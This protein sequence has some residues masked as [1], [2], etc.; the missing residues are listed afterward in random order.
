VPL[1]AG[2]SEAARLAERLYAGLLEAGVDAVIDDRADHPG[3]KLTDVE[4]VGI[5]Y[6][7]VVGP[8]G[9]ADGVVEL[10]S[11]RSGDTA[12]IPLDEAVA[13]VGAELARAAAAAEVQDLR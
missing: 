9:L 3:A 4:L 6:R 13:R 7:L 11:R 8:R 1:T 10:T 12:R 2:D 5:P